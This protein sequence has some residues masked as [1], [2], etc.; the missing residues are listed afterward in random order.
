V[1]KSWSLLVEA[2]HLR[3][4]AGMLLLAV[5]AGVG[6]GGLKGA[7]LFRRS[8]CRN[9]TRIDGLERPMIWQFYR[10]WFF[11]F[12]VLMIAAGT[13]LSRMAH[14]NYPFL[15]GVAALDLT[16]ATALLSSGVEFWKHGVF[17]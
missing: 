17:R 12:L 1:L 15:L 10:P 4:G 6:V 11:L 13:T 2:L 8:C 7:L 14:G 16:I 5:V 9:L 3:S